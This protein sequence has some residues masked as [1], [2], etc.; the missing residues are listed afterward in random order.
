[1]AS[2]S[3]EAQAASAVQTMRMVQV[4]GGAVDPASRAPAVVS[5]DDRGAAR[6]VLQATA[7]QMTTNSA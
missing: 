6:I 3:V 1:M 4:G 2:R 5:L 7:A